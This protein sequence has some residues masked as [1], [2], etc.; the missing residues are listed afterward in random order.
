MASDSS[1]TINKMV[2]AVLADRAIKKSI[3]LFLSSLFAYNVVR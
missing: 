2:A 3:I 1:P